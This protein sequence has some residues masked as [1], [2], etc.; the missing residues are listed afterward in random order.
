MLL[1]R[2]VVVDLGTR[3]VREDVISKHDLARALA[4]ATKIHRPL[5]YGLVAL[6]LLTEDALVRF[7]RARLPFGEADRAVLSLVSADV[8]QEIP[9]AM[10]EELGVVAVGRAGETLSVAMV[11]PSNGHAIDEVG[12]YT[13]C[14]I[15]PL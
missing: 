5:P 1:S 9:R 11:D 2:V 3:L 14:T 15:V 6:G 7:F 12:F 8:A 10:A 13:G 4:H